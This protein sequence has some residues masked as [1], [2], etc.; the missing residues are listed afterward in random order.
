M[1]P[2]EQET[3]QTPK[4][5]RAASSISASVEACSM[6]ADSARALFERTAL[7]IPLSLS[8]CHEDCALSEQTM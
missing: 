6:C 2:A 3:A 8:D 5:V 1:C 7:S 4:G